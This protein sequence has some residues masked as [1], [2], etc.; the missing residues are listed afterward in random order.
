L[1][2]NTGFLATF[3]LQ[4]RPAATPSSAIHVNLVVGG[5]TATMTSPNGSFCP[6]QRS[7]GA[8]GLEA[9]HTITEVGGTLAPAGVGSFTTSIG[10]ITC[11]PPTGN[12]AFD[13]GGDL[14][15]PAAIS[16]TGTITLSNPLL[17]NL[18]DL[19]CTQLGMCGTLCDII[20]ALC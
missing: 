5:G 8:F 16:A 13:A 12:G 3:P 20:P 6:A 7:S 17:M 9:A 19:L 4:V 15:G 2:Q 10:A 14:P 18:T 11:I 1:L